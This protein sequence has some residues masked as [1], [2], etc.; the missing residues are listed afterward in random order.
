MVPLPKEM[1]QPVG[2]LPKAQPPRL[3]RTTAKDRKKNSAPRCRGDRKSV[4]RLALRGEEVFSFD[5]ASPRSKEK[6][7]WRPSFGMGFAEND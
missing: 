1:A 3:T 7:A 4:L 2:A 6:S 5:L